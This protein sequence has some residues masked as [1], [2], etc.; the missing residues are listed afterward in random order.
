[1]VNKA[2]CK[3]TTVRE[4]AKWWISNYRQAGQMAARKTHPNR[5]WTPQ[6]VRERIRAGLLVRRLQ[7]QALG[8][9]VMTQEQIRATEFLLSRIVPRAEPAREA[10]NQL[11]IN[12]SQLILQAAGIKPTATI[13]QTLETPLIDYDSETLQ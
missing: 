1:M 8:K 13:E 10:P 6:K 12:V 2:A 4:S 9:I 3:W 5:V 7:D 11:Q